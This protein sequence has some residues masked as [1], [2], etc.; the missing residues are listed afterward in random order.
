MEKIYP[1]DIY[2]VKNIGIEKWLDS[3]YIPVNGKE[4]SDIYKNIFHGYITALKKYDNEVVYW[5]AVSNLKIPNYVSMYIAFLFR[6][7][8]LKEKGYKYIIGQREEEIPDDISTF[9]YTSLMVFNLIDTSV[10]KPEA[11]EGIK[12]ISRMIKHNF[13]FS[14]VINRA[15]FKNITDP[16]FIVGN[17]SQHEVAF[18]MKAKEISPVYLP[19]TLF[20]KNR[21]GNY[22]SIPCYSDIDQFVCDFLSFVRQE[23]PVVQ[24]SL[25]ET[26]GRSISECFR[27]SLLFFHENVSAFKKLKHRTLY[28]T[29]LGNR[30]HRIFCS[31]WRYSGGK[32]IG[33]V[34][35]NN[36]CHGYTPNMLM[37]GLPI[38]N[39]YVANSIGNERL[40]KKV[41]EDF[42][43][44]LNMATITHTPEN[45]YSSY[46]DNLQRTAPVKKIRKVM[47]IG[48]PMGSSYISP[49][50]PEHY[51]LAQLNLELRVVKVLKAIG[52][53]VIYK[54]HPD[55]YK[56]VEGVFEDYVDEVLK[57]RLE[58][59]Y[60]NADC[61]F[62][63]TP[64]SSTFGFALLT[65]K[66]IVLVNITGRRW[67]KPV[68][69][70]L[71]KRCSMV[72]ADADDLGK[73][74]FDD[75]AVVNAIETSLNN[76]NY[77]VLYEF[78]F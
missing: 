40:L 3:Y 65:N 52:Y 33:F 30:F 44:G 32:V 48:F 63:G 25:F 17:K 37:D 56:E 46:F 24:D 19:L 6:L 1:I 61:L 39:E 16:S 12:N 15:F 42:S 45:F 49:W 62:F 55:R 67:Y 23:Y 5:L 51:T 68:F 60:V 57:D 71:K 53:Y 74:I 35:G 14:G 73:I 77:D 36:Y 8:R 2:G 29:S 9:D 66:P 27:H 58:D 50:L 59:V 26:L 72:Y 11:L 69:E 31:A 28:A 20:V 22:N 10:F 47:L 34:H 13:S 76:I 43:F 4:Y 21:S 18:Y 70:L 7:L 78:A 41:T 38:V 75:E 64:N 54:A